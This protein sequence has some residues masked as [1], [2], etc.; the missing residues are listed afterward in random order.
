MKIL[1]A[2]DNAVVRLGLQAVLDQVPDVS[3]T[4]LAADGVQALEVARAERPDVVLLDV[5]MPR[6]SGLDVL[7]ELTEIAPVLMMTHSDEPETIRAALAG[8]ARGY[9]VHGTLTIAEIAAAIRTCVAG[10]MVLG[11]QAASAMFAQGPVVAHVDV[12]VRARL[13]TREQQIMDAVA[14]GISNGEIAVQEFLSPKT[15]KNHVNNIYAK[16]GVSSRAQAMALWVGSAPSSADPL[17][18][19]PRNLGP[20]AGSRALG[21]VPGPS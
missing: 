9:L 5:R 19:G 4:L 18:P 20:P 16:L 21:R 13:S 11:P 15:V 8:G 6:R 3:V 2:D 14:T 17:G 12:Q 1:V 7:A 10:G